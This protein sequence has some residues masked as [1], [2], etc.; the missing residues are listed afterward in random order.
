MRTLCTGTTASTQSAP[1]SRSML[2]TVVRSCTNV[3]KTCPIYPISCYY[4]TAFL[5]VYPTAWYSVVLLVQCAV[6]THSELQFFSIQGCMLQVLDQPG[7]KYINHWKQGSHRVTWSIK[8]SKCR[9]PWVCETLLNACKSL[10]L[11]WT[12][13]CHELFLG[14]GFKFTMHVPMSLGDCI[15]CSPNFEFL[16]PPYMKEIHVVSS[17]V[18]NLLISLNTLW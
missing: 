16:L 8:W 12:P 6:C 4:P 18:D 5:P 15:A 2:C 13:P 7:L 3:I 1:L 11:C 14:V 17:T 9:S 10:F